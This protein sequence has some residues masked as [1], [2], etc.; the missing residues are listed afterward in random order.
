MRDIRNEVGVLSEAMGGL[1]G[2]GRTLTYTVTAPA[3]AFGTM[4]VQQASEFDAAMRNINSIV[5]MSEDQLGSLT[6]QVL[7]FGKTTRGGVTESANALYTVFS[8][9]ILDTATAFNIMTVAS[10]TAEAGLADLEGTTQSIVGT[11]LA[12][13]DLSQEFTQRT[14]DALTRM[15]Q[16]GVGT[17]D[18]FTHALAGITPQAAMMG[19]SLEELTGDLAFLTQRNQSASNA[20]T[21]LN[22]A[23]TSLAK[24]TEAMTAAMHELGVSGAE[25]LI[26][27][28]G[29]VNGAFK[30][31]IGTTNGTQQEIQALF[32]NIRGARAINV[33]A[34][35][36]DGW[37]AAMENFNSSI[38]GSTM[39]AWDEQSKSFASH[40]DKMQS[41][42]S[43]AAIVVGQALIPVLI[44]LLDKITGIALAFTELDPE[45]IQFG[46]SVVAAVAAAGPL[47]WLFGGLATAI[48][49]VGI[50]MSLLAGAVVA[51]WEVISE[52]FMTATAAIRSNLAPFADWLGGLWETVAPPEA[53]SL[54][55]P[56]VDLTGEPTV[57]DPMSIITVDTSKSLWQIFTEQGYDDYFSWDEFMRLA[58]AGGWTG[59][60]VEV[61]TEITIDMTG[62][63]TLPPP[64]PLVTLTGDTV[65][66]DEDD[67]AATTVSGFDSAINSAK[68]TITP[69]WE[70][71]NF[72]YAASGMQDLFDG[73]MNFAEEIGGADWSGLITLGAALLIMANGLVGATAS[74]IGDLLTGIGG[75]I[76][77]LVD[78]VSLA[79][80]GDIE[81]ALNSIGMGFAKLLMGI[82]G[83]GATVI[84][85]V[86][87]AL[88]ALFGLDIPSFSEIFDGMQAQFDEDIANF[89]PDPVTTQIPINPE[90][91]LTDT[92]SN[93]INKST[94][95]GDATVVQ[96]MSSM[97][98]EPLTVTVP[99]NIDWRPE[100]VDVVLD[101]AE[102]AHNINLSDAERAAANALLDGWS[103]SM[104]EED[105]AA[106][107]DVL[108][109]YYSGGGI[110]LTPE[111]FQIQINPDGSTVV[112]TSAFGTGQ[113]NVP[114]PDFTAEATLATVTANSW[115]FIPPTAGEASATTDVPITVD[116]PV[117]VVST[118]GIAT[119]FS[120][121]FAE[122]MD[123]QTIIDTYMTPVETKWNAM[124]APDGDMTLNL[125]LFVG[126][127]TSQ[128]ILIDAQAVIIGASF[129]AMS[130]T[131]MGAIDKIGGK[132]YQVAMD[133]RNN[134]G[135]AVLAIH[136]VMRAIVDLISMEGVVD[137]KVNIGTSLST[138]GSHETG[139]ANVP[140]DGYTATLHAG[141]QVLT[142]DQAQ[143][144]RYDQMSAGTIMGSTSQPSVTNNNQQIN[145]QTAF[146]FDDFVAEAQRRGIEMVRK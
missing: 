53:I 11:Q 124:F 30:A 83:A 90:I 93:I 111:G 72:D 67:I 86:T 100:A 26:S 68:D 61:G 60:A 92:F 105:R 89:H 110:V 119:S 117:E 82:G 42:M 21:N 22:N 74:V 5:G 104:S 128:A 32:N 78:A 109:T 33:F 127:M 55:T 107:M 122:G 17:M 146:T 97:T 62:V 46:L 134:F 51:N 52:A 73:V 95:L 44:P 7:D 1:A 96:D 18:E 116:A 144:Y 76:R 38:E 142:K 50:A 6:Q 34:S 125:G 91:Y 54:E 45:V 106:F 133:M 88:N 16:V 108:N 4:A 66:V 41:A 112:L 23:L 12:Y 70:T 136:S 20:A 71:L 49:P 75:A 114:V 123:A 25:E 132:A 87:D 143:D 35:D 59:G 139:L 81:G 140:F 43:A 141:E 13:N 135:G 40:F 58:E 65:A 69:L 24:P 121:G 115:V 56:E 10:K 8:A 113:T 131:A 85:T 103:S 48:T 28:F 9:G 126:N 27:K 2:L 57:I 36:I 118:E 31:L 29:G 3:I 47:L 77:G 102:I 84:T 129:D 137:V 94:L 101:A 15:V 120:E 63:R 138:D 79:M 39:R 145:V 14:S 99:A 98:I 80:G 19:M 64:M 37:T 130:L